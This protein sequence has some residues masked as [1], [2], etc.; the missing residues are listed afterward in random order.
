MKFIIRMKGGSGS[1][2][3]GH[4]GIPGHI[5]G[6]A[7]SGSMGG[8]SWSNSGSSKVLEGKNTI[9]TVTPQ[10]NGTNRFI[11]ISY[12]SKLHEDRV[13]WDSEEFGH[14]DTSKHTITRWTDSDMN[15][16]MAHAESR[17]S[18]FDEKFSTSP[19]KTKRPSHRH[20]LPYYD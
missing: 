10:K 20:Q 18:E 7:P 17:L 11:A 13:I 3:F 8:G 1:G 2:N 19:E 5:G 12:A 6:S 14:F 4:E 15:D 9:V 16:A